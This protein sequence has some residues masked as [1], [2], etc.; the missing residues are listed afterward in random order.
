[1]FKKRLRKIITQEAVEQGA[2]D[3]LA[4][5]RNTFAKPHEFRAVIEND[6]LH[7]D[8]KFYNKTQG[9]M[10]S[11]GFTK[12]CDIEDLTIKEGHT[13]PRTFLRIMS[14]KKSGTIAAIYHFQPKIPWLL[15]MFLLIHAMSDKNIVSVGGIFHKPKSLWQLLLFVLGLR[16]PKI[17]EFETEFTDGHL[18]VTSIVPESAKIPTPDSQEKFCLPRSTSIK[19]LL[20]IHQKTVYKYLEEATLIGSQLFRAKNHKEFPLRRMKDY[21]CAGNLGICFI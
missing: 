21:L 11:L 18:I 6:F 2:R 16:P 3:I 20:D 12:V 4:N 1:M 17:Y 9:R 10:E 19:N 13:D 8:L 15:L 14:N 5:V 7:L